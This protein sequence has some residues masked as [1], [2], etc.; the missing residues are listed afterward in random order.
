MHK[1]GGS[2]TKAKKLA[3]LVKL[4]ELIEELDDTAIL[5]P[6]NKDLLKAVNLSE[7]HTLQASK[8]RV[9][10]DYIAEPW[11]AANEQQ[12]CIT[13]SFYLQTNAISSTLQEI[14]KNADIKDHTMATGWRITPHTLLESA[15]KEIGFFLGKSV[16]HTWRNGMWSRL[17]TH[18]ILH[19]LDVPIA[20]REN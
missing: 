20:V 11:G 16:E 1:I 18:L 9:F 10:F 19:G 5:L 14:Y 12:F 13:V 15:N 4:L 7:L 6:H 3:D 17:T 8:I 2:D